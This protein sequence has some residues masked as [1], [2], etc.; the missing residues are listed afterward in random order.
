MLTK[1]QRNYLSSIYFD[2][3]NP[4]AYSGLEMTWSAIRSEG[5]VTKRQLKEWLLEQD[6]Y[7]SYFPVRRKFKRP[8]TVS[9]AVDY[10]WGSDV[11]YMLQ[12]ADEN[13]G[14][15]YFVVFIDLFSRFARVKPLKTLRG[16]EMVDVM[17]LVFATRQP[18]Y[19]Y[20][21]AGSEYTNRQVQSYLKNESIRQYTSR[22]EK[23]VAHAERLIKQLKRKLLQY[24]NEKNTYKWFDVLSDVVQAYNNSYHR[25]IKM[26][27]AQ[28]QR[29]DQYTVWANQY[30]SKPPPPPSTVHGPHRLKRK[31]SAFTFNVGDR[32]KLSALK[33]PFDREYDQR[34]TT[35]TF[36]ITDR[37]MQGDV[38]SYSVKDE[39]NEPIIGWFYPQELLKVHVRDDKTY[40]IEKV[41]KRRK[42]QGKE[43]LF[44]KFR[45]YPKKFNS[46]VSDVD[47][48]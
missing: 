41:L 47:V 27:P 20:T 19:L 2:P 24:M 42:R 21:D 28:A 38:A 31:K 45:G 12:F 3:A 36:T 10:Y 40:K 32:V 1:E 25:V 17:K 35:E 22:N 46:W 11:A 14:Y 8:R 37:R 7:T 5:K 16:R 43:E 26:T 39:Q 44:V 18:R 13:D 15:G 9:P 23:K 6:T 29:A 33:R 4:A 30:F 34:Y 48:L